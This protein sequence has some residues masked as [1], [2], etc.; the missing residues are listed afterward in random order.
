MRKISDVALVEGI[1][2]K[3]KE[4]FGALREHV[5]YT[6]VSK[7]LYGRVYYASRNTGESMSMIASKCIEKALEEVERDFLKRGKS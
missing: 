1:E 6:R 4:K 7:T 3:E 2:I 5:I